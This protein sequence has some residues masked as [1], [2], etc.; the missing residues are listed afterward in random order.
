M[1]LALLALLMRLGASPAPQTEATACTRWKDCQQLALD[2]AGRE[3]FETFHSLAWRAVQ[4]GPANDADLMFLLARAQTLSGRAHD[5]L[6]ML[7]R[8]VDRGIVHPEVETIDDFRRVRSLAGWPNLLDR[9]HGMAPLAVAPTAS[10]P[11]PSAAPAANLPSGS[12]SAPR[13]APDAAEPI[14]GSIPLP[15]AV[16]APVAMAYDHVSGRVVIA[17][18]SSDTIK[19]L[20]ELSGNAVD[21]VSRG[22]GGGYHTTA[23]AID[24]K[25]GDLW[26]V[27]ARAN[28]GRSESVVHRMQLIS[29][30]L[31]Y[32]VLPPADSGAT[33]FGAVARAAASV[34]VLDVEGARIFELGDGAKTLRLRLALPQRNLTGLTLAGDDVAY[35]AHA[36]GLVRIG[37]A[38][39]RS[40]GVKSS[41]GIRL[42]GIEWIGHFENSILAV[43]RQADGTMAAVRFR[44]D[45]SG[46]TAMAVDTFGAAASRGAAVLGDTFFYVSAL[47]DGGT[48]VERVNLRSR[49]RAAP[50]ATPTKRP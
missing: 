29:G 19:V 18:D 31:L 14:A 2:A 20:S 17:D 50:S 43:Q 32:T 38:T 7:G 4:S 42:E 48:A 46:R 25:R 28:A 16:T 36:G 27:G 33:R 3:D 6:V 22:W 49:S 10:D 26:V 8:L 30:R 47:P 5:A 23:L 15:A 12:S 40:T 9:M 37:L 21:L 35:V 13:G 1:L 34:L 45:R 41:L 44:F 11:K 39:K 24:P